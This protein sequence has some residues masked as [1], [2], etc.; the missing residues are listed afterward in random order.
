M[1]VGVLYG[2]DL[3]SRIMAVFPDAV[4]FL[5]RRRARARWRERKSAEV[6]SFEHLAPPPLCVHPPRA[7]AQAARPNVWAN[8]WA[9][10]Y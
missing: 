3:R 5:S 10:L 4:L 8:V 1:W 6:F 7:R 2:T 9:C